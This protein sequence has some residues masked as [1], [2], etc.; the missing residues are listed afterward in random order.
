VSRI[1]PPTRIERLSAQ[2]VRHSLLR[3]PGTTVT[4]EMPDESQVAESIEGIG[5]LQGTATIH[6]SVNIPGPAAADSLPRN[7][8][9]PTLGT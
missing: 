6:C 2:R 9:P 7:P 8:R 3:V 5:E 4:K 1:R